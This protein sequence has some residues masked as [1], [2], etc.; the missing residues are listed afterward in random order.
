[1]CVCVCDEDAASS[2]VCVRACVRVSSRLEEGGASVD[3]IALWAFP[4]AL[5]HDQ[6]PLTGSFSFCKWQQ[7]PQCHIRLP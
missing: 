5:N 6:W 7:Y 2:C 3:K 1:M 4:L